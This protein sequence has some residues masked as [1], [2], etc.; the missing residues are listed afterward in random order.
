MDFVIRLS[1]QLGT[2]LKSLRKQ[3]GL[4]Q[5]ELGARLSV[6]QGRIAQ[7]EA[8]PGSVSL[9]QILRLLQALEAQMLV[10]PLPLTSNAAAPET[11]AA[12]GAS[13]QEAPP[14]PEP[15]A[16]STGSLLFRPAPKGS[17]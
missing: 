3:R 2:Q 9:D 1:E 6:S 7:I 5:E 4:S 16:A 8:Q 10:R 13:A 15:A 17:W 14:A 11:P 12:E